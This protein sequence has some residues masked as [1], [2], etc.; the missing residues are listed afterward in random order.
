MRG[1]PS[2]GTARQLAPARRSGN[3]PPS[4]AGTPGRAAI[5][6]FSVPVVHSPAVMAGRAGDGSGIATAFRSAVAA[7][8]T[9]WA[10]V[11]GIAPWRPGI[12]GCS[13][14]CSSPGSAGCWEGSCAQVRT[15]PDLHERQSRGLII[16]R[17][18]VRAPPAPPEGPQSHQKAATRPFESFNRPIRKIPLPARSG[19]A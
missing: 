18:W 15:L 11:A 4:S 14:G 1:P 5:V 10:L 2:A 3:E 19:R 17:S 9:R 13:S 8:M 6:R 12:G 16:C 7:R